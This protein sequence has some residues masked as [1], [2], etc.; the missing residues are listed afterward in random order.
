[1]SSPGR[2]SS[3]KEMNT[4]IN[5]D[6]EKDRATLMWL[7][8]GRRLDECWRTRSRDSPNKKFVQQWTRASKVITLYHTLS[9]EG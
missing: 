4:C 5:L 7:R 8:D 6:D 9:P 3:E 1:M 2:V